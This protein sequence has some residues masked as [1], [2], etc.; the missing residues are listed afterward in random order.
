MSS[1]VYVKNPNGKTYVYSNISVY[2]KE[3]KKVK[4]IRKSIGHLDP[5]T[6]EVVPNRRKGDIARKKAETEEPAGRCVVENTGI[7]LLLDKAVSDIGLM[8]PLTTVFPDDWKRILTCAYYLVSEG[9]A[10]CHVDQWQRMYP[11]PCRSLLASQ[12][13]SELLARITPTLQQDFFSRWIEVNRQ[14]DVYAMDITS[15]SSYSELIDFVR[16][17]YNRDGEKLPQINLLMLTGVSSHMPLYYRIIPGSIKD[18]N[19]LEDSLTNISVLDSPACHF[20]MD[21]GFYSEPNLDAM[22]ES[23]KKFLVGVPFTAGFACKAVERRRESIRSHHNYCT[24]FGDE[25]YAVTESSKWKGHRFYI[26]IYHD[27]FK[28]AADE[29]NFDHVLYCCYEELMAG[30]HVKR[31]ASYYDQFFLIHET[32]VRGIRVNYNEEAISRHKRNHIGWFVLVS[33]HIK[34]KTK[35]LE[36]YRN[37]DSV[38]KCFD[39]LKNDLDMKRLRIHSAAAMEGRIFIQFVALLITTRLKQ[40]MNEAGWYKNH[41]LQKVISEMKTVRSVSI[42]GTR[43]K[44]TTELTP[45][46]KDIYELY[47]LTP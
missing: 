40:V 2:D 41:D 19:T 21:K 14:K 30:R 11:S 18:V 13:V 35:A 31:H 27:S 43:K 47:G 15:V 20:V 39:D 17:G 45:F 33:N 24:V 8:L 26:H 7:K 5:V 22:Y 1:L 6:G 29:R 44:Y 38:E 36:V 4:H 46:Q 25:L 16:W 32:P 12:R 10:L 42:N 34:D 28:A 23:H 3:T 37:K 9:G